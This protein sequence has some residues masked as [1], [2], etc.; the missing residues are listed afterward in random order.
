LRVSSAV[1]YDM[2]WCLLACRDLPS[3]C[4]L[5]ALQSLES[6]TASSK[7]VREAFAPP[8]MKF[9]KRLAEEAAR[10]WRPFYLDYKA[11]K[12]AI[13]RDVDA[14]GGW[15]QL[16]VLAPAVLHPYRLHAILPSPLISLVPCCCTTDAQG[17]AFE[18][19]IKQ[20]LQ[21]I[22]AFYVDKEEEL[23]VSLAGAA[24]WGGGGMCLALNMHY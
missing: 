20:E 1:C 4:G 13:Q 19:V 12:R 24:G 21:K 2:L 7:A 11:V 14:L 23:E 17:H 5:L 3:F 18:V 9:G 16:T 22:S 15:P 10:R 6:G 8:L